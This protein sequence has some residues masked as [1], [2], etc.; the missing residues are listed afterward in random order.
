[1]ASRANRAKASPK[2]AETALPLIRNHSPFICRT[3]VCDSENPSDGRPKAAW[4]RWVSDRRTAAPALLKSAG[5]PGGRLDRSG[6]TRRLDSAPADGRVGLPGVPRD[7][8]PPAFQSVYQKPVGAGLPGPFSIA[9]NLRTPGV[10]LAGFPWP[11][12]LSKIVLTGAGLV[13]KVALHT[14]AII[15]Q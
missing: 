12:E 3:D 14:E 2:G 8:W 6:W 15:P 13:A 11:Q 1:M 5:R 7:D 10:L 4:E 9:S